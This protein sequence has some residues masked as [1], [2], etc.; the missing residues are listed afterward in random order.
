MSTIEFDVAG[1]SCGGCVNRVRTALQGIAGVQ[2]VVVSEDR[3]HVTVVGEA[4]E[5]AVLAQMVRDTGYQ[6]VETNHISLQGM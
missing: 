3:T 4:L 6:V 2:D 1:L 5:R